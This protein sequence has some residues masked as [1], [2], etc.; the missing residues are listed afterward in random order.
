MTGIWDDEVGGEDRLIRRGVTDLGRQP[1][2]D[3]TR[4]LVQLDE[5]ESAN[6]IRAQRFSVNPM[7]HFR[8]RVRRARTI[9]S[10][11]K[12]VHKGMWITA[13]SCDTSTRFVDNR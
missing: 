6:M 5:L 9:G 11:G 12:I 3:V 10:A 13:Y 8:S 1:R 4:R 7:T 2:P